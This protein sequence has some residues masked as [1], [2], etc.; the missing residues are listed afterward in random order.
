M[1]FR[2]SSNSGSN[3][4]SI[5]NQ[6]QEGEKRNGR[7]HNQS[8]LTSPE[9]MLPK[10][11]RL[12]LIVKQA[13]TSSSSNTNT[14]R[15]QIL[16]STSSPPC[17]SNPSS[18]SSAT[19]QKQELTAL[20]YPP[21]SKRTN[22][23]STVT[24]SR[25]ASNGSSS[26]SSSKTT[27]SLRQ[28]KQ[29]LQ[30]QK[31]EQ[32]RNQSALPIYP[33][34]S[35]FFD[36]EALAPPSHY[37]EE[38]KGGGPDP[39]DGDDDDNNGNNNE[40]NND[41][42]QAMSIISH[43]EK[44]N[45][46][47]RRQVVQL[48]Q[49]L[50]QVQEER[51]DRHLPTS[52]SAL[53]PKFDQDDNERRT[54]LERIDKLET[55]NRNQKD[56]FQTAMEIKDVE[57]TICQR[58]RDILAQRVK[59]LMQQAR[60]ASA[61]ASFKNN[62]ND[63]NNS[64]KSQENEMWMAKVPRTIQVATAEDRKSQHNQQPVSEPAT[65]QRACHTQESNRSQEPTLEELDGSVLSES[66]RSLR[67]PPTTLNSPNTVAQLQ[68]ALHEKEQELLDLQ[69]RGRVETTMMRQVMD[70]RIQEYEQCLHSKDQQIQQLL[71]FKVTNKVEDAKP[72]AQPDPT[73]LPVE[74]EKMP[75]NTNNSTKQYPVQKEEE[76][77]ETAE[78]AEA[79]AA[80]QG[81]SSARQVYEE[82]GENG[83]NESR[84]SA[85]TKTKKTTKK[86]DTEMDAMNART[87]TGAPPP[88]LSSEDHKERIKMLRHRRSSVE[89]VM[90]AKVERICKQNVD[91]SSQRTTSTAA[92]STASS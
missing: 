37:S 26:S 52:S 79:V 53:P 67:S 20:V 54:L 64:N 13:W 33:T 71:L 78:P 6:D 28:S 21:K 88:S 42:V 29:S 56:L 23:Q 92:E 17:A 34:S 65:K 3:N 16:S 62:S 75:L 49:T 70:Q 44:E 86:S 57:L 59:E 81:D 38:E 50:L 31:Q 77:E 85:A 66:S 8:S 36:P 63:N 73:G 5:H 76:E 24:T 12:S 43:L 55:K 58:E 68:K 27:K 47:Y 32:E 18:S 11:Q 41:L 83:H 51:D 22:I 10:P 89:S 35:H 46:D 72:Q 74:N 1:I 2:L 7:V 82:G 48:R 15:N 61:S 39:S 90:R 14:A 40:S 91:S 80:L 84:T 4:K 69:E 9:V 19:K 30:K 87:L 45:D 25:R 60:V